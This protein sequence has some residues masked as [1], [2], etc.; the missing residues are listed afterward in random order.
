MVTTWFEKKNIGSVFLFLGSAKCIFWNLIV[1]R[2]V[3]DDFQFLL[4]NKYLLAYHYTIVKIIF[5]NIHW[6]QPCQASNFLFREHSNY[7]KLKG[8]V[9]YV[10]MSQKVR[11]L[12]LFP[13]FLVTGGYRIENVCLNVV[14]F[15][16]ILT[17][18]KY[19]WKWK[20]YIHINLQCLL[21]FFA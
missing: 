7:F 21:E 13:I 18:V 5:Q 17:T 15:D 12:F 1:V 4:D 3:L 9:M 2:D 6:I 16:F 20:T 11:P 19:V 10:R 14:T 8:F